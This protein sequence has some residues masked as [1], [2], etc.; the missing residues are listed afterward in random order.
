MVVFLIR[1]GIYLGSAA[2]G[3]WV[4]SLLLDGMSVTATGFV[5]AVLVFVVAQWI[6]SPLILK[7]TH[8]Y[9]NAFIGGVGLVSTFVALLVATLIANG[10]TIDGADTWV[11]GTLVVWLVTALATLVLPMIF[12]KN[13]I[14]ER[15]DSK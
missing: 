3:I 5:V 10:L 13:R 14:E 7:L 11:I 2:L 9:A 15:R 8:K 4:A 6:L 12:L 1:T